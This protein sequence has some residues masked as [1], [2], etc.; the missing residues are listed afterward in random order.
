MPCD[1]PCTQ[2]FLPQPKGFGTCC[3]LELSHVLHCSKVT[4]A[5]AVSVNEKKWLV[6]QMQL[7]LDE[8]TCCTLSND[9]PT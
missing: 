3:N 4:E 1:L 8:H 5:E 7:K 2:Q 6:M 9:V